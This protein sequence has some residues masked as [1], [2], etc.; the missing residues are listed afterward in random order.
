MLRY[1][2]MASVHLDP[3]VPFDRPVEPLGLQELLEICASF[4]RAVVD[5][6]ATFGPQ[7][8][9]AALLALF[10]SAPM[11][12]ALAALGSI[13][14][15]APGARDREP[16]LFQERYLCCVTTFAR[17]CAVVGPSPSQE[18]NTVA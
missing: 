3:L 12:H 4:R 13:V 15:L 6:E 14:W 18:R 1:Q 8:G 11:A 10:E 16:D 9:S 2:A 5:A 7:T 17:Q